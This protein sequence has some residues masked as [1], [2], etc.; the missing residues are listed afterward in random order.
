MSIRRTDPRFLVPLRPRT[1][2]VLGEDDAWRNGLH[3]VG[4]EIREGGGT[5]LAVAPT[6]LAAEAAR[7]GAQT[8]VVEGRAASTLRRAGYQSRT[9]LA[10]P[11]VAEPDFLLPLDQRRAASYGV[12]HW[13]NSRT[14]AKRARNVVTAAL[15]RRGIVPPLLS[16]LTVG[17]RGVS[18]VPWLAQEAE[19]VAD[20]PA[21]EWL[22]AL[23]RGDELSR[24]VLLLFGPE[25]AEPRAALKF[26]RVA[27]YSGAFDRDAKG[28][29]LAA[30]AGP[31]VSRHAPR[32]LA[33][34][35]VEGLHMILES[36]ARGE[37]LR[38]RLESPRS[39][40]DALRSVDAL[41]S[42]IVAVAKETAVDPNALEPER[43]RLKHDVLPRWHGISSDLVDGIPAVPAVLQHNDL[44]TWNIVVHGRDFVVVDWESAREAGFPLWDLAYF[45]ADALPTIAGVTDRTRD[46]YTVRLFR[47]ET[48]LSVVLFR[49]IRDAADALGIPPRAVA[50]V[51]TLC[52]L[53]HGLS[54]VTRS[55]SLQTHA[56]GFA[57]KL[58]AIE[59]FAKAWLADPG[60]GATWAVWSA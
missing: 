52:W 41:A 12:E 50:P 56:P 11:M 6:G 8:V 23:G 48:D 10:R 47:G 54:H 15:L 35:E 51:V 60:L 36:A 20:F 29:E 7:T 26:P 33:R 37:P 58:P 39:R 25:D 49:W 5:D 46:E 17:T 44:G 19:A 43:L 40:N 4:I 9:Y 13:A 1:A 38:R 28:L 16:S 18:T 21:H 30:A 27:R 22:L 55:A 42:W 57:A 53:H 31:A 45:L 3:A 14:P 24:N 32:L 59:R 34:F 2:I